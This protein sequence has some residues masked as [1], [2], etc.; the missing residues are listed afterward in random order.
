M[1]AAAATLTD[2]RIREIPWCC[3]L[4]PG[5]PGN[6]DNGNEQ[7][8][9]PPTPEN[10][11]NALRVAGFTSAGGREGVYARM[12]WPEHAD[13]GRTIVPLD[14]TAAD[15]QDLVGDLLAHLEH[16]AAVGRV[17]QQVLDALADPAEAA[18]VLAQ[19]ARMEE[20]PW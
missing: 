15:Y 2:E 19:Q 9:G 16:A 12:N 18:R 10:M 13:G 7:W 1:T 4:A 11:M 5:H 6:H 20:P 8:P 14:P 3:H 17:A